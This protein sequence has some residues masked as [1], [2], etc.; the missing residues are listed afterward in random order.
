MFGWNILRQ[1]SPRQ[2]GYTGCPW[3]V[4]AGGSG[5]ICCSQFLLRTSHS[6][7]PDVSAGR[8]RSMHSGT[9]EGNLSDATKNEILVSIPKTEKPALPDQAKQINN[10]KIKKKKKK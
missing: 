4:G 8:H 2:I 6:Y 9:S 7:S 3:A 5:N 1:S 10:N